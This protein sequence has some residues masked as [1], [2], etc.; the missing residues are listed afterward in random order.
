MYAA[1]AHPAGFVV[2]QV[3]NTSWGENSITNSNAPTISSTVYGTTG[4][5][6]AGGYVTVPLSGMVTG[7]ATYSIGLLANGTSTTALSLQSR[8][9]ANTPQLVVQ[10]SDSTPPALTMT[11]PAAGF[12]RSRNV[13]Y[14]GVAGNASGDSTTVNVEVYSGT[15][16]QGVPVQ[17]L[18][19]TRSGT[20]W[21]VGGSS[22]ADG[23]YTAKAT[24]SDEHGNVTTV[25][26]TYTID[27]VAP[28][29]SLTTPAA[30]AVL[31]TST[32]TLAGA[33]GTAFGDDATVSVNVYSGSSASGT[34]VQT[35]VTPISGG[36]WSVNTAALADGT[37]T[38]RANQRDGAGNSTNSNTRTF[39]VDTVSPTITVTQPT[40]GQWLTPATVLVRGTA[41]NADRRR[42][43]RDGARLRRLLRHRHAGL[44]LD[45]GDQLGHLADDD[46]R[47]R[48]RRVHGAGRADGHGRPR[49]AQRARHLQRRHRPRPPS[50]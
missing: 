8:E 37:Y 48:R 40:A 1:T 6:S 7:N 27:N 44:Q 20:S 21:S 23:T 50:R 43:E 4:A 17:T 38:A 29:V 31:P 15:L 42:D 49:L 3:T 46:E 34:P 19:D 36:A 13:T 28:V 24:Q 35:I 11:S 39:R 9:G 47:A 14:S 16:A 2:R 33:G 30:S 10:T 12:R 25:L 41:T 26:T 45:G 18:S 5:V 32:P 22:L